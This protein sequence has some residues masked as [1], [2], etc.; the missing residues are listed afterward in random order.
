[1]AVGLH[2]P[3]EDHDV[4]VVVARHLQCPNP[5]RDDIGLALDPLPVEGVGRIAIILIV[6]VSTPERFE[7]VQIDRRTGQGKIGRAAAFEPGVFVVGDAAEVRGH[8]LLEDCVDGVDDVG[9]APEIIRQGNDVL[10]RRLIALPVHFQKCFLPLDKQPRLRETEAVDALLDVADDE[11]VVGP[12]RVG[13]AADE[14]EEFG[15]QTIDI[16]KL[17]YKHML[18][19]VAKAVG[20][21]VVGIAKEVERHALEVGEIED[22]EI[23]LRGA[24]A[25][26]ERPQQPADRPHVRSSSGDTLGPVGVGEQAEGITKIVLE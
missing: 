24:K 23:G 20:D 3:K 11:E 2:G 25:F 6:N 8:Q 21:T 17:I 15:L 16:L 19:L 26:S 14:S 10:G 22:A 18:K 13:L 12:R 7:Y 5:L 9:P 4:A 1:M